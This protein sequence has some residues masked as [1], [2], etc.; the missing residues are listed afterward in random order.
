MIDLDAEINNGQVVYCEVRSWCVQFA[1]VLWCSTVYLM[2]CAVLCC[3]VWCETWVRKNRTTPNSQPFPF[4]AVC[5]SHTHLKSGVDL[6]ARSVGFFKRRRGKP[7]THSL[8]PAKKSDCSGR[9]VW[10]TKSGLIE[11]AT[12]P[13]H[14]GLRVC[15]TRTLCSPDCH[16]CLLPLGVS[17]YHHYERNKRD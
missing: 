11:I 8:T 10:K 3:V 16:L 14:K 17:F 7:S 6:Q 4:P 9:Q 15:V 13:S 5:C 1:C 2:H 12:L